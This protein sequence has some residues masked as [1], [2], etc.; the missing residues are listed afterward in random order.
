MLYNYLYS[1][2]VGN[3]KGL[4]RPAQRKQF[5]GTREY[6]DMDTGELTKSEGIY[7]ATAKKINYIMMFLDEVNIT[8]VLS[9]LG[10]SG[11]VLAFILKEYNDK[12]NM[13]YFSTSNKERMVERLGL[14]IGTVRSSVKEFSESG[15]LCHVR[16]AEYMLNPSVYYK[17]DLGKRG[18]F[19]AK[20]DEYRKEFEI[21]KLKKV[22]V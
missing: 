3:V 14:S 15:L 10:S 6:V 21:K 5:I 22:N 16:G 13:F 20:Y 1:I 9:G 7:K 12:D 4:K 19:I 2:N 18:D 11:K 8:E 17:G